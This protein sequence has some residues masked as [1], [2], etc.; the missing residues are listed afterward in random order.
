MHGHLIR[1]GATKHCFVCFILYRHN[2]IINLS[3]MIF[4]K[5]E[6]SNDLKMVPYSYMYRNSK[7]M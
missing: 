5:R 7:T 1:L 6:T 3:Y 2:V 4:F